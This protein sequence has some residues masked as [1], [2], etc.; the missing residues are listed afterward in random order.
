LLAWYAHDLL[1]AAETFANTITM[2]PLKL[3]AK[4]LKCTLDLD[5]EG[6][7]GVTVPPESPRIPFEVNVGGRRVRGELNPKRAPTVTAV[8]AGQ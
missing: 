6:L 4:S 5:P 8:A 3:S 1:R 7:V 2:N